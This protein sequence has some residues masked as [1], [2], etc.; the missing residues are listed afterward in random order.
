MCV[1]ALAYV[2]HEILRCFF[3]F[4]FGPIQRISWSAAHNGQAKIG[5]DAPCRAL[6]K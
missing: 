1:L 2:L 5:A 4:R 3:S 6:W